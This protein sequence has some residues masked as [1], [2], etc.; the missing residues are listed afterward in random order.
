MET[1]VFRVASLRRLKMRSLNALVRRPALAK[2]NSFSP[3]AKYK[4]PD[5]QEIW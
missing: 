4:L 5:S 1:D 2:L 3:V